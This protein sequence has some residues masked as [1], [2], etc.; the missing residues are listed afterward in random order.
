VTNATGRRTPA[1]TAGGAA[2]DEAARLLERHGLAIL[3][4]NYRTRLGEIDLVAREGDV[5]VFVE[6]RLRQNDAFGDAAES[7]TDAKRRRVELAAQQY[8]GQ[9]GTEPACRFDVVTL[10]NGPPS[11]I[12]AAF[13][14]AA[15]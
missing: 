12:K 9:L 4:R 7:I 1:Q 2:E 3:S 13:D 6:V 5:L 10:G 11:W 15:R 14:A 8:L